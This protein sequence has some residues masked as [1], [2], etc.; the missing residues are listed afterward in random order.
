MSYASCLN[1]NFGK[2]TI[3]DLTISGTLKLTNPSLSNAA[4]ASSLTIEP[5]TAT[6]FYTKVLPVGTWCIR[7]SIGITPLDDSHIMM[8][9]IICESSSSTKYPLSRMSFLPESGLVGTQFLPFCSCY[10]SNGVDPVE[11]TITVSGGGQFCTVAGYGDAIQ[12]F[13]IL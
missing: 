8:S 7:G 1:Y 2:Q 4:I 5:D 13:A 3:K 11:F 6:V 9:F 10:Q 12:C